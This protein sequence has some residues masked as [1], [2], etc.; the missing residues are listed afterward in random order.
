MVGWHHQ[1]N[2]HES[3]Q[4]LGDDEGQGSLGCF[5]PWACKDSDTNERLNA[6]KCITLSLENF[7]V[8]HILSNLYLIWEG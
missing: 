7:G 5:S 6:T 1:V 2:G 4:T 8:A 3:E